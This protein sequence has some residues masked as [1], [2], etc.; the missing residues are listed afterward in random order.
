MTSNLRTSLPLTRTLFAELNEIFSD[1]LF[2]KST[3]RSRNCATS[4]SS[5]PASPMPCSGST[6]PYTEAR[7]VRDHGAAQM[8]TATRARDSRPNRSAVAGLIEANRNYFPEL[9][10]AAE[11]PPRRTECRERGPLRR[12]VDAAA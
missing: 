11:K 8:A 9:E 2:G 6:Q 12:A 5:C 1:P 10:T 7:R 4:P 3:C